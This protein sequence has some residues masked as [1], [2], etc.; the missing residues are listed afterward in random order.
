LEGLTGFEHNLVWESGVFELN[1]VEFG[2][3]L[4]G[5]IFSANSFSDSTLNLNFIQRGPSIDFNDGEV[6][7]TI[8][9][10]VV[11]EIDAS[12]PALITTLPE[13]PAQFIQNEFYINANAISIPYNPWTD[14]V[15]SNTDTE[16][17]TFTSFP[18][19]I[20]EVII[21]GDNCTKAVSW[22]AP[23]FDD[24]CGV[25]SLKVT[26]NFAPNDDFPV[27]QTTVQYTVTDKAGNQMSDSFVV[28]VLDSIVPE[29]IACPSNLP[30][31]SATVGD[32]V[33]VFFPT[34]VFAD[35]CELVISSNF[36]P[37]DR[38]PI[39]TTEVVYE[40]RDSSGNQVDC[41]F[42]ITVLPFSISCP[43]DLALSNFVADANCEAV[44]DSADLVIAPNDDS[45]IDSTFIYLTTDFSTETLV[46][47]G[48][49]L[50]SANGI[51]LDVG[52]NTIRYAARAVDG[53]GLIECEFTVTVIDTIAPVLVCPPVIQAFTSEEQTTINL[54]TITTSDNCTAAADLQYT[55]T[56]TRDTMLSG[57][58]SL[59]DVLFDLD[60]TLVRYVVNDGRGNINTCDFEVQVFQIAIEAECPPP[61]VQE[62]LG[63]VDCF[64][65]INDIGITF[66][67]SS[68]VDS[69]GYMIVSDDGI[70]VA[71]TAAVG[72]LDASGQSL[73]QGVYTLTYFYTDNMFMSRQE[74]VVQIEVIDVTPPELF[75]IEDTRLRQFIPEGQTSVVVP[76]LEAG[77]SDRCGTA[78][79]TYTLTGATD[80]SGVGQIQN[81]S[82]NLGI[83][84]VNYLVVDAAGNS[85]T[86]TFEV[87]VS[88]ASSNIACTPD[89]R[90]VFAEDDCGTLINFNAEITNPE[91]VANTYYILSMATQDTVR[92][93]SILPTNAIFFNVGITRLDYFVVTTV[94]DTVSCSIGRE[95]VDN[96][97]PI[98]DCPSP[99]TV[100]VAL[101][102]TSTVVNNLG[103][104][105]EDNCAVSVI[106]SI[107]GATNGITGTDDASGNIFNLGTSTVT[108][109]VTDGNTAPV[110][111]F[112]NVIVAPSPI[113]I[114]CPPSDTVSVLA[115]SCGA[116]I[117]D[118]SLVLLSD[119]MAIASTSYSFSGATNLNDTQLGNDTIANVSGSFFNRGVTTG[120]Y[121]VTDT[122]GISIQCPDN[123][124]IT[125][126]DDIE[127]ELIC[128]AD[129]SIQSM[130]DTAIA[131][132]NIALVSASDNCGILLDTVYTL[133]G[134]TEID[135][136]IDAS[137]TRFNVGLTTVTYAVSDEDGTIGTCTFEVNVGA[138][139][140]T[141]DCPT[142]SIF[143]A[144]EE[145]C[146]AT[147][148]VPEIPVLSGEESIDSIVYIITGQREEVL[149]RQSLEA[150]PP[151]QLGVGTTT[152]NV[153]V[154]DSLGS[155]TATC[156][157]TYT[158]LDTIAPTLICP[159][160]ILAT[161]VGGDTAQFVTANLV[162]ATDNC[163]SLTMRYEARGATVYDGNGMLGDT[164]F[165]LGTTTVQYFVADEVGNVDSCSFTITVE[166]V[167]I[168]IA[169]PDDVVVANMTDTCG[170]IVNDIALSIVNN[171]DDDDDNNEIITLASYTLSGATDSLFSDT[172]PVDASGIFFN[173][174]TTLVTYMVANIDG[175]AESCSF[176]VVVA[177]EQEPL[178]ICPDEIV[179][180]VEE[181]DSTA[182]IDDI[183][184]LGV[185][186]NCEFLSD[187]IFT[188]TGA[189][190]TSGVVDASGLMF[191]IGE[192]TVTYAVSDEAGNIGSCSFDVDVSTAR[193]LLDC[194]SDSIFYASEDACS[195]RVI[196]P[197][198]PVLNGAAEIDSIVYIITGE[199][200]LVLERSNLEALPSQPLGVGETTIQ[201]SVFD[202]SGN[203][204]ATCNFTYTV[205]DTIA[206]TLVC[207][208]NIV[209]TVTDGETIQTVNANLIAA[210]DNCDSL[211]MRYEATGATTYAG[212]GMLGDT[213]F[214]LGTTTVQYFVADEAGNVDS[215][216]FTITV[217][218]VNIQLMCPDSVVV[219]SQADSCGTLVSDLAIAITAG[220]DLVDSVA[221]TF[222]GATIL[223]MNGDSLMSLDS[224]FFGGGMTDVLVEVFDSEDNVVNCTFTVTVN[225]ETPPTFMCADDMVIRIA[226]TDSVAV[227]DNIGLTGLADNCSDVDALTITYDV[228]GAIDTAG[229]GSIGIDLGFPVG[230]STVQY[231]IS[232][233]AGNLDSCSFTITVDQAVVDILC[234]EDVVIASM[235]DTCGAVVDNISLMLPNNDTLMLS[236]YALSGATEDIVTNDT[237]LVDASGTFFNL[238]T[239]VVT[240]TVATMAG[241]ESC[242]FNVIVVDEQAPTLMC[243]A[244][245]VMTVEEGDSSTTVSDIGLIGVMDNCDDMFTIDYVLSGA[246]IDTSVLDVSG[247]SFN[248]G[249][250]TV[251]YT[252][253]DVA[254]NAAS[255]SF[256]V[257]VETAT[258]DIT[259]PSDTT[260]STIAD[261]C[262]G[263][264]E[265]IAVVL[266]D[267]AAIATITYEFSGATI[268]DTLGIGDASGSL[269]NLGTTTV[270][271]T[272]TDT[273]GA[274][275]SCSFEV[276]VEDDVAPNLVC[277]PN[278]NITIPTGDVSAVVNDIDPIIV[279]DNCSDS[280]ILNYSIVGVTTVAETSG[281]ASGTLFNRG[282]SRVT[283]VAIDENGNGSTCSFDVALGDFDIELLSCPSDT[284]IAELIGGC[285][286]QVA[287]LLPEIQSIENIRSVTY[288]LTGATESVFDTDNATEL[289]RMTTFGEGTTT[290]NFTIVSLANDTLVCEFT[291][292]VTDEDDLA[293]VG[294]PEDITVMPIADT[295]FAVVSWV[296]PT[297]TDDCN[298]MVT[299]THMPGDTFLLG[300]TTVT[301]LVS[302]TNG[303]ADTCEFTVTVTTDNLPLEFENCPTDTTLFAT[304]DTCVI[305]YT[306]TAPTLV[307]DATLD[308]LFS[309]FVP[310]DGFGVGENEV[311]YTA[312]DQLGDTTI[313][314]FLVTVADTIAP[315]IIDCPTDTIVIADANAC[316][317]VVGWEEPTAIDNCGGIVIIESD[318]VSG[319][320]LP[321]GVR[322][323]TYTATDESGNVDSC[324]FT[325][326]IQD[327]TPPTFTN[328]PD[329]IQVDVEMGICEAVATW[330]DIIAQ[331]NCGLD[332]LIGSHMPGDTFLVG[333]TT[334]E[335]I[336]VDINGNQSTCSFAVIVG[337]L[338]DAG[339]Q[340]PEDIVVPASDG[341]CE[342]VATWTPPV[343]ESECTTFTTTSNFEPGDTFPV[344]STEVVYNIVNDRGDTTLCTFLVTI[345]DAELPVFT[346]CPADTTLFSE[347]GDCEAVYNWESPV[348]M[349]NCG[350]VELDST[351]AS[352]TAFPTGE[353]VVRYTAVDEAG[354]T[355]VCEF[356]VRVID[357]EAPVFASCPDTIMVRADGRIVSDPSAALIGM[358]ITDNCTSVQLNFELPT[359]TDGCTDIVVQQT[360]NTG[361]T[362]GSTFDIGT[363]TLRY[364]ATDDSG[365]DA[366]CEVVIVVMPLEAIA[367]TISNSQPCAG[368][369][370][371][372]VAEN[373]GDPT[374]TY[375]WIGAFRA[376]GRVVTVSAD[377]LVDNEIF[378]EVRIDGGCTLQGSVMVDPQTNPQPA[379]VTNGAN[380][381]GSE[382][383]LSGADDTG[384][385]IVE[386]M[387]SYPGIVDSLANNQNQTISN[388]SETNEGIYTLTATSAAGCIGTVSDTITVGAPPAAPELNVVPLRDSICLGD[389]LMLIGT[390]D[391]TMGT[392]YNFAGT[393]NNGIDDEN[394]DIINEANIANIDFDTP[395]T[396]TVQYWI[397]N[398]G[399]VSD[400][401]SVAVFVGESP[402]ID[403]EFV[404]AVECVGADDNL[405][406]VEN[407]GEASSYRWLA[408]DS[409]L[410]STERSPILNPG[411][412]QNGV[413]TLIASI[414]S[415]ET[416]D[417][418]DVQ[419]STSL[420]E[421]IV[422]AIDIACTTDTLRLNVLPVYDSTVQFVWTS[423]DTSI[424]NGSITTDEGLL[425]LL[426]TGIDSGALSMIFVQA[427]TDNCASPIDTVEFQ[428]LEGPNV[429]IMEIETDYTCITTDSMIV[430]SEI[431]GEGDK[432]NW[433]G[434]CDFSDEL[435]DASFTVNFENAECRSGTYTVRVIGQ[436]GCPA[437]AS[438]DLDFTRGLPQLTVTGEDTYCEGEDIVL[439]IDSMPNDSI[440]VLW[441]GPEGFESQDSIIRITA[442]NFLMGNY[443]VTLLGDSTT[444]PSVPSE[445]FFVT[446]LSPPEPVADEFTVTV[447]QLDS[448]NVFANDSLLMNSTRSFSIVSSPFR[449]TAE[450]P[451]NSDRLTYISNDGEIGTD[452]FTYEVC[453]EGCLD[454]SVTLCGQAVVNVDIVFPAELCIAADYITPNDDGKNDNFIVSCADAG[455]YPNNELVVFNEWGDEV[456]RAS[457][458]NND[459]DGT[460]D[461]EELPDGT[462]FYIFTPDATVEAQS[463]F[464]TLFR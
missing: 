6:L 46:R 133:A 276:T 343:M 75:C 179:V 31:A 284:T 337:S 375:T 296:E 198:I 97:Q 424:I 146:S 175:E 318:L 72:I 232:D 7:L 271:Y 320:P 127:P 319:T 45:L 202:A 162:D 341:T 117:S 126:V 417:T 380:C 379:I 159:D 39:G 408:P 168:D 193:I 268:S 307:D 442:E 141:L 81:V 299:S 91:L 409:T 326:E 345:Q 462:Y 85:R 211:T 254:G 373:V 402:E 37:G 281:T 71:D 100:F 93:D 196:I 245:V 249:V 186:D 138:A 262:V 361:L 119:S 335:Y 252:A 82:F 216:S 143:Y 436:N 413:Y 227:F 38:F 309:N 433:T 274:T 203:E 449:G 333:L 376:D 106:Y 382:L 310:G 59:V 178:L 230:V 438:V 338:A 10:N 201:I 163:D 18:E 79:L 437:S 195:A 1:T 298:A 403:L 111:C 76:A 153:S 407:V 41:R 62:T 88:S 58:T 108:Y 209:A 314:S 77:V 405:Q 300:T 259:C 421:P 367:I 90:R 50:Q 199:R 21:D 136:M 25:D 188:L 364:S 247:S 185:T 113:D 283:Y 173:L 70:V 142:D 282:G 272:V 311:I 400:T 304:M 457:P 63:E 384:N 8:V 256:T 34:P 187:T 236:S 224:V 387:W 128:P 86:C 131:I 102:D 56:L 220:E 358:P 225:D 218:E 19:D 406:L 353:T 73:S 150:L 313:C 264:A 374:A 430:L 267:S 323:V 294:C 288:T 206:P 212:N 439:R 64:A 160:E 83:T 94:G 61:L 396:Y 401:A 344:G 40:A 36:E 336:A 84:Q 263:I 182:I 13:N 14:G 290:V 303:E 356:T 74:C 124:V 177:D 207:P 293:F 170:A 60:T 429:E 151:Q 291:V 200:E 275:A 183:A 454:P 42:D 145:A 460:H 352:G 107:S 412:L 348:A 135:G 458:Y 261:S 208:A 340:C 366:E 116:F 65:T 315:M 164:L 328:C 16:N 322:T 349:D 240:Y 453:Y 69:M 140:V 78:E 385:D 144:S 286:R 194:P 248:L 27:G 22:V 92:A 121:T 189:T 105:A 155:E 197:E 242:A 359:A 95:V 24:N 44:L 305:D 49:G 213:L 241:S 23:T 266:G 17:P 456:F 295:T 265:N 204:A 280:L 67:D 68:L 464:V 55:Y 428:L 53:G 450:F 332:T 362:S 165:N 381:L 57:N 104:L 12:M 386:W 415:C 378:V 32:S 418:I 260:I 434:P 169:C 423:S 360:D 246:T 273:L 29:V 431:S 120:T 357:Q 301:Y 397:N 243:P 217:E 129:I 425:E 20:E 339:I 96:S 228:I 289:P 238:D 89:L 35:N 237:L 365:N 156:S 330:E 395:G 391:S 125:V 223:E 463:G 258:V 355:Q 158:V 167:A 297:L 446:V 427:F 435:E 399:C 137:G 5:G 306:W 184:L 354:N 287:G 229:F 4:L 221:Y 11:G 321:V 270:T 377:D 363:T 443:S 54:S 51:T 134:A 327:V 28:T 239:T 416:T 325:I 109:D 215:C 414:G 312:V 15:V 9:L 118:L 316:G 2:P 172:I 331:D 459:W 285:G 392:I 180:F 52:V 181:G 251:T 351:H 441:T 174:D 368:D 394:I 432:I 389:E 404:G 152:I 112:F 80:T 372:L 371:T 171:D 99:D 347:T 461:G 148:I 317:R 154:F 43:T 234:P 329:T 166:Q 342:G 235:M 101:G 149:V 3:K 30:P 66:S 103:I 210:T 87:E 447:D 191:N 139:T 390:I 132:N 244:D 278:M 422:E 308:T 370:I 123:I 226:T 451:N 47:S 455:E 445:P 269:L 115:D 346:N 257:T 130:G 48:A 214:N 33:Q 233:E 388:V 383:M 190:D 302:N 161:V 255:C 26:S 398:A 419:V 448:L 393:R 410:F 350:V 277:P 110:T 279:M 253:T 98:V 250:T 157:F 114:E 219:A 444:C 292:T 324:S 452:N 369:S 222:T 420:R 231:A 205:L 192:T 426:P 411:N 440:E 176:T 122:A 147:A 334:V